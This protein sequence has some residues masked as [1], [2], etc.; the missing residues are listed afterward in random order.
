MTRITTILNQKGGTGKSTTAHALA[1]GL[2]HRGHKCLVIDADAQG[3]ISYTMQADPR[4]PGLYEAMRGDIQPA[5]AIQ[6]TAQ[7]DIIGSSLDLA[8]AD[9]EFTQTGREY[10]LREILEPISSD[11]T[12]IIIDSPPALG[13]MSINALTASGDIVIPICPD[14]YSLQGLQQL[15]KNVDRVRKYS[16]PGISISGLLITRKGN[17]RAIATRELI[18]A[19]TEH[20][21]GRNLYL[22]GAAIREAVAVKEA[23][24]MRESLFDNAPGAKV[25]EDYNRFIDEYLA[26]EAQ[27]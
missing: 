27:K 5:E 22:Y 13:I 20:A 12:H 18:D 10:L 8:G 26:Q 21:A 24:I 2:T 14:I 15:L 6:H 3:N 7:G 11:Y 16:N 9:M 17:G 4:K 19:I 23:Q 25:T 1:T